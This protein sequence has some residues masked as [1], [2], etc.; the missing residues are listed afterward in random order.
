M[1]KAN[2]AKKA[3]KHID[4]KPSKKKKQYLQRQQ[5]QRDKNVAYQVQRRN[6]Y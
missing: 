1:R 6:Y 4:K 3:R 5:E 2:A